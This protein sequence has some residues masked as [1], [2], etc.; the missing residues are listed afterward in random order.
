M[1]QEPDRAELSALSVTVYVFTPQSRLRPFVESTTSV[2]AVNKEVAVR[3]SLTLTEAVSKVIVEI[4]VV[5]QG[6]DTTMVKGTAAAVN[7]VVEP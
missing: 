1:A 5:L 2:G 4:V 6:F 3:P 7:E